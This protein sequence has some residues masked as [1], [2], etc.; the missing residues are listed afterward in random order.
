MASYI[1]GNAWCNE[2]GGSQ[3]GKAGDQKQ[4]GTG[5]DYKGEVRMQNL[6]TSPKGW[7]VLR[8]ISDEH[9]VKAAERMR[10]ACNNPNIGYSQN[11]TS[12]GYEQSRYGV[13]KYGTGSTVKINCDCSSLVRACVKEATGKDPGD[14]S[15]ADEVRTLQKTG[16]FQDT[17]EYTVGMQMF[18]GD[19]IVTKTKGHT[20]MLVIADTRSGST[21]SLTDK[22]G[23]KSLEEVVA[24]VI[25]GKYGS[26]NET[27]KKKV[28]AEGWNYDTVRASVNCALGAAA[29]NKKSV[30]DNTNKM[31]V[32]SVKTEKA[33][34]KKSAYNSMFRV[35]VDL[36]MRSGAGTK[37][38]V[39]TVIPQNGVCKCYGWYTKSKDT[40]WLYVNFEGIV[41]YVS[42]KYLSKVGKGA[43]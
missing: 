16:L 42:V 40:D 32:T 5:E 14:F 28:E 8:F 15:T 34:K 10:T 9:A 1:I 33:T 12:K 20:A 2:N 4:S 11:D 36:N 21:T 31:L 13:I 18:V 35:T 29:L 6:Y 39:I 37:N 17:I 7:Y 43:E 38:T 3:N 25:A 22:S 26:G 41:G 19:I 27:R 24:D 23:G 30:S